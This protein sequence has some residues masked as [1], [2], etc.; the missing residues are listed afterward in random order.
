VLNNKHDPQVPRGG[1]ANDMMIFYEMPELYENGGLT[2][3]AMICASPCITSMI[4]FSM[5]VKYGNLFETKLRMSRRR[6]GA[7]GNATTFLLAWESAG[8]QKFENNQEVPDLPS[9]GDD[10]AHVV[11]V[12]LKAH[13]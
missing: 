11:H 1:L 13:S 4:C 9:A 3:M 6:A 8:V 2:I 10:A 7:R 12:L 5:E